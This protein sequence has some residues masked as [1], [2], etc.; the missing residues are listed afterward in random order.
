MSS[1]YKIFAYRGYIPIT[2]S[3]TKQQHIW[4]A[5]QWNEMPLVLG[6]SNVSEEQSQCPLGYFP[7]G[8]LTLCLPQLLHCNGVDDCGNQADEENCVHIC[9]GRNTVLPL[10]DGF[11]LKTPLYRQLGF[12][13]LQQR[14]ATP[15]HPQPPR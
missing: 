6:V 4:Q 15:R 14:H 11:A 3:V 13:E 5:K 10:F 7:C 12:R 9:Q 2:W 8:N 1:L